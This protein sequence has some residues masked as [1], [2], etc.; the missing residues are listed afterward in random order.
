MRRCHLAVVFFLAIGLAIAVVHAAGAAPAA[1]DEPMSREAAQK[2]AQGTLRELL[3]LLALPNDA[4][5]PADIVKNVEVLERAFGKRG[6]TTRRLDNGGKPLL[7]AEWPKK[8]A[9]ARTVLFYMHLDGQPVV[10]REWSQPSPWKPVVK[11]RNAA[12][13]WEIVSTDLLFAPTLD[14][15][16]RVFARSAS[17]DKAPILMFLAAFDGLKQAGVDPAI[18]VKVLLDSEEEKGSPSMRAVAEANKQVLACDALIIQDGPRHQ[19]ER[20]TLVFGNRGA[21][22]VS[23]VVYGPRQPLHSG[24]FGNYVPNPA[25]RLARLIASMKDDQGRVTI[26]GYYDRVKLTAA[27]KKILAETGD[28]EAAIRRRTGISVAERVGGNLQEALQF[29]SLNVR[30]MAAASVGDKAANVIPHQAI[31]DFDL[32]TTPETPPE[33]LFGLIEKHVQAQGY[34]LVKGPPTDE[35]RA[36]FDKLATLTLDSGSRAVRTP[37]DAPLGKWVH[38]S[39][40]QSSL[41]GKPVR[42]RMMG[43]SVPTDS[44]VEVLGAPFVIVPLVNGDNNQ[45]AFDEN[46]RVGHYVEGIRAM[47]GMLRSPY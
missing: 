19:S 16:L 37:L 45:H 11:K 32:R 27:E 43:G 41:S 28:D 10:D 7:F 21:A 14:P 33:Y 30:G 46:L 12:G 13:A 26:R 36:S 6:F 5:N 3:E 44:L 15:E 34:H 38:A 20:P 24:H 40:E 17:D 22:H 1:A 42:I 4:I 25:M 18:N 23:L 39:L 2:L 8:V 31:A 29:P 9:G 47:A 35:E